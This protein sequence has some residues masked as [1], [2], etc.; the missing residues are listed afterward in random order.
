MAYPQSREHRDVLAGGYMVT[1]RTEQTRRVGLMS[2]RAVRLVDQI[3]QA[4]FW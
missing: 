1:Q 2:Q 4:A 3:P